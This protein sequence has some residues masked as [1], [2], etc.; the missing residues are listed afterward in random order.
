V[1]AGQ[2]RRAAGLRGRGRGAGALQPGPADRFCPAAG[3]GS[4]SFAW[5][6]RMPCTFQHPPGAEA[7]S[8]IASR[9]AGL[10]GVLGK[11][12][13]STSRRDGQDRG[14]PDR[15]CSTCSHRTIPSLA[16]KKTLARSSEFSSRHSTAY[17]V[18]FSL[19][20]SELSHAAFHCL[21]SSDGRELYALIHFSVAP[22]MASMSAFRSSCG[23][24]AL[25]SDIN[26]ASPSTCRSR[27]SDGRIAGTH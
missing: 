10:D 5:W 12:S 27:L 18:T 24:L 13:E 11:D 3:S 14:L 16:E 2:P 8:F 17:H 7:R 26:A 25:T 4:A 22:S 21:V 19:I 9:E 23:I 6:R 15:S 20:Q 1:R